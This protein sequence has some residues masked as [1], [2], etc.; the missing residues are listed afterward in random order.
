M[1]FAPVSTSAALTSQ[2]GAHDTDPYDILAATLSELFDLPCDEVVRMLN[3][4]FAANPLT[5]D[6]RLNLQRP[7]PALDPSR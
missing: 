7:H 6:F 3:E 5:A 1:S 4:R 2:D